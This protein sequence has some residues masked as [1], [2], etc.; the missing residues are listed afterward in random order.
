MNYYA[1]KDEAS[2]WTMKKL[3]LADSREQEEREEPQ[4]AEAV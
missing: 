4:H 2:L 1:L 3:S